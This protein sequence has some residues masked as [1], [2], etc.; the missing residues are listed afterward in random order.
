MAKWASASSGDGQL[1]QVAATS[2]PCTL[3]HE[4]RTGSVPQERIRIVATNNHSATVTL[5]IEWG[6]TTS[7]DIIE[8]DLASHS[9]PVEICDWALTQGAVI[10][11]FAG[12]TNVIN[13]Y[14]EL[15]N[16]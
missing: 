2:T 7:A 3:V 5:T 1:I 8:V 12:T 10:R 11:A 14:V 4:T 15:S 13:L 16:A 6:G 9:G